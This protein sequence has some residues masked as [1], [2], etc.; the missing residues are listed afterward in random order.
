MGLRAVQG[1]PEPDRPAADR[2]QGLVDRLGQFPQQRTARAPAAVR[3]GGVPAFMG[4]AAGLAAGL[5]GGRLQRAGPARRV[6]LFP[7]VPCTDREPGDR[8]RQTVRP[9]HSPGHPVA[10]RGVERRDLCLRRGDHRRLH[11]PALAARRRGEAARIHRERGDRLR[12]VDAAG[13]RVPVAVPGR[14]GVF[15][16]VLRQPA[17]VRGG[18]DGMACAVVFA[19]PALPAGRAG[20]AGAPAVDGC[21]VRRA[22]P[23]HGGH[24]GDFHLR[25]HQCRIR[26]GVA[27]PEHDGVDGHGTVLSAAQGK[28]RSPGIPGHPRHHAAGGGPVS[29]I[30]LKPAALRPGARQERLPPGGQGSAAFRGGMAALAVPQHEEVEAFHLL[31]R[32][33]RLAQEFQTG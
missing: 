2:T 24:P 23:A 16:P 17:G 32:P 22:G 11:A 28:A 15:G 26:R 1:Q 20:P 33:G 25:H 10:H 18:R 9:V 8:V 27:H 30:A 14:G 3:R 12:G 7:C 21:A 4:R 29:H 19:A 5:E 6:C 31:A 13:D